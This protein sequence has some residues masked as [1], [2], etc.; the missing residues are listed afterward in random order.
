M[1]HLISG[2]EVDA[3]KQ[4]LITGY[5]FTLLW[6][7]FERDGDWGYRSAS[8]KRRTH[9]A[10]VQCSNAFQ[11]LQFHDCINLPRFFFFFFFSFFFLISSQFRFYAGH[12]R[13]V[14]F[15]ELNQI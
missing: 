14:T 5:S 4:I 12:K 1:N 6:F 10:P 2:Y 9:N 13:F 15:E 8:G 3:G 7:L 11:P